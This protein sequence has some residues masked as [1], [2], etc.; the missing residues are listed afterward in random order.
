MPRVEWFFDPIS[1]YAYLQLHRLPEIADVVDISYRPLLF[2]GLLNH[3]GQLG[4]AEIEPKRLFTYRHVS[5]LA[6]REKVPMTLPAAHPFNPL[7]LLRLAALAGNDYTVVCRIFE[8]VWRDGHL[9]QDEAAFTALME[10]SGIERAAE[11][12][13][14]TEAKQVVIDNGKRATQLGVFGVPSFVLNGEQV[15]WG[16]DATGMLTD[17]LEDPKL[18]DDS[19]ADRLATLPSAAQRQRGPT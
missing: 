14:S 16:N 6:R 11:R 7:P 5:W 9:P 2:A 4:P 1:P 3:W 10:D 19:D 8:F 17:L 18:F 15:I 12:I 13:A